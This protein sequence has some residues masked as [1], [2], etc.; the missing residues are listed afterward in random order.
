MLLH[1]HVVTMQ[2]V[3]QCL[4]DPCGSRWVI[5]HAYEP[6]HCK[7]GPWPSIMLYSRDHLIN[8]QRKLKFPSNSAFVLSLTEVSLW[9]LKEHYTPY[10]VSS[11]VNRTSFQGGTVL[12]Q[13]LHTLDG[14]SSTPHGAASLSNRL[15]TLYR[16]PASS[17]HTAA[18]HVW[19]E[20]KTIMNSIQ[21]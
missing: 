17:V 5:H 12:Q 9:K 1:C 15:L 16:G 8:H 2:C 6:S 20:K 19:R 18:T 13:E 14:A 21:N 4:E 10:I 3:G 11:T 7:G